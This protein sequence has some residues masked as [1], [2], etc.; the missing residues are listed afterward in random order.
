MNKH[1]LKKE[2]LNY[3][4]NHKETSFVEIEQVFEEQGFKYKGN[5]AYIS[6]NHKNIIFWMGW[7][8]EAFNIVADLKRDGLIEMK[9]CPPMYY[10][11][12]GK[13]LR[14]PIVKNKNLKSD[15]WLPVTFNLVN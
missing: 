7:N 3:I 10:L 13:G 4:K 8:E 6:G 2:I 12:D 14:L 9:I 1:K 11:I 15:H 5:G